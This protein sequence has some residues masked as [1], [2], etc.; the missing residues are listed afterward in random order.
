MDASSPRW[1][2]VSDSPHDHEREAL[3]F[4][5]RRLPDREPYRVWSNFEFTTAN[6]KLYEVDALAVTDNG[7]HLI[8]IKSHPGQIGGDGAAWQW[9]T[10]EG[11]RRIFD[12]PRM[13]ANNK[14]KALRELLERS[15]AFAK[16][17]AEV[18]YVS[19][20]VF[21]SDP[22]LTVTL[23]PPGRHRVF[24]RDPEE[25]QPPPAKRQAIGGMV[26]ALTSLA[27]SPT[28]RPARR[29]D[30][31]T[32]ARI[33]DAI[34]QAGIR[35]RVSRRRFGDYRIV[36]LLADI[37]ADS[38]TGIAYQDFLVEHEGLAGVRRRLRLYPLEQNATTDQREAAARAAQREFRHLHPL[39]HP[40]ILAPV[41]YFEHER[42]PC[43]LFEY[44]PQARALDR[45]LLDP[46]AEA[47]S[48]ARLGIVRQVAEAL[49]HAHANGVFHRALCPSAVLVSGAP[50]DLRVQV[51]NWHAGARVTT[52]DATGAMTGTAHV[53][54]LMA[55]DAPLYRAPEFTQPLADPAPLDVFSLGCLVCAIFTA[56]PPAATPGKLRELLATAG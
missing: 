17:R 38:D 6:G 29:I 32:G 25:G 55:G 12:N 49:A 8:E 11:K 39:Q 30:R 1:T 56:N 46:P 40:R 53:E 35:E 9:T 16:H 41:D 28:G 43:L 4:L 7:V 20:A 19:E 34:E 26:E 42:G 37:D 51:A 31:P 24:G 13:L 36:E 33:A 14:A 44:D 22:D 45:W 23:S 50:D 27:P 15:K 52:G 5:R 2:T 54:A 48:H 3:A 21:L 10:P 47:D 18:P